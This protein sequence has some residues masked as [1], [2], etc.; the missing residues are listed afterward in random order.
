ML[1]ILIPCLMC[2]LPDIQ[3][4]D[5]LF[6]FIAFKAV[7][8]GI[9]VVVRHHIRSFQLQ[10]NTTR[11]AGLQKCSL[12]IVTKHNMC[13]FNTT[14]VVRCR[15]IQL[16]DILAGE[17]AGIGHLD[18]DRDLLFRI[19]DQAGCSRL[20]FNQLPLEVGIGQTIAKRIDNIAVIHTAIITE[21]IDFLEASRFI[22]TITKEDAFLILDVIIAGL[23]AA[24]KV[25]I[26]LHLP[27]VTKVLPGRVL[28]KITNISIY[29]TP[30]GIN[31]TSQ[32]FANCTGTGSAGK[33]DPQRSVDFC[34]IIQ[35]TKFHRLRT[36]D[37]HD[38][39]VKSRVA[40]LIKQTFLVLIQ[41]KIMLTLLG[42][43]NRSTAVLR[44]HRP[45]KIKAL[46]ANAGDH[47]DRSILII[48]VAVDD[49]VGI[50]VIRCLTNRQTGR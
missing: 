50:F 25:H 13:F 35:E 27:V 36:V 12:R 23:S 4:V 32:Y 21:T 40:H 18:S 9:N 14:I 47:H 15:V 28:C 11:F 19:L 45:R 39:L 30:R 8:I 37:Q 42:T 17:L 6:Q 29:Q 20:R 24:L 43:G 7:A 10:G 34:P 46:A 2:I 38:H 3:P 44:N 48:L 1:L 49:I 16:H 41:F 5:T 31:R 22:I 33:A 26:A